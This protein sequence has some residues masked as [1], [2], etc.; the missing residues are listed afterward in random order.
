MTPP[1]CTLATTLV[2]VTERHPEIRELT[3]TQPEGFTWN[4]GDYL[5]LKP[6]QGDS[7]PFS[8]ASLPDEGEIRLQIAHIDAIKPWLT[9]LLN[10]KQGHIS[11]AISQFHWPEGSAPIVCFAGGTGITP[12]MSLLNTQLAHTNRPVVLYWGVRNHRLAYLV[13]SLDALAKQYPTFHYQLI[14]SAEPDYQ[15]EGVQHGLIPELLTQE[16]IALPKQPADVII[17]GPW[18]MVSS[19]QS[20]L[21]TSAINSLQH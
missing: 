8:I 10:E 2:R 4:A 20:A 11:T 3:L 5:W 21:P 7:K 15:A 18:M 13:D 12:I 6:S 1:D 16:Q 9:G 17:C 14:L 19:I